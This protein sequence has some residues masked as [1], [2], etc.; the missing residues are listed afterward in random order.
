MQVTTR[1]TAPS[2]FQTIIAWGRHELATVEG[3]AVTLWDSIEPQLVAEAES[4][5]GQFLGTAI[6]AVKAQ[7]TQVLS[8]HEKFANAKDL[9]LE[10]V[11]ANG[12]TIGNTLL[13]F[14]VNLA[15]SLLRLGGAAALL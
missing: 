1:A 13:E 2:I 4:A 11:E 8:G 14:I 10:A 7:A 5:V 9:V 3:E 15:L 6:A 12:R